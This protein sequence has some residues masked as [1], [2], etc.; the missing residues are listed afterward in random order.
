MVLDPINHQ[1]RI[2][3]GSQ[4]RLQ[5]V[6][7]RQHAKRIRNGRLTRIR[8]R[9]RRRRKTLATAPPTSRNPAFHHPRLRRRRY[10]LSPIGFFRL[11]PSTSLMP[12]WATAFNFVIPTGGDP[13]FLDRKSGSA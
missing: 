4:F 9:R 12:R 5:P 13:D 6:L 7:L 10:A 2:L 3:Q 11:S 1:L 8:T